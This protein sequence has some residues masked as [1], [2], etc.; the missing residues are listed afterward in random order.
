MHDIIFTADS[1]HLKYALVF[2]RLDCCN[3]LLI[4]LPKSAIKNL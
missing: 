2:S 1:Q 4:V 3:A